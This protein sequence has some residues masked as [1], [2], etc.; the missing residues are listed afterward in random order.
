MLNLTRTS[1]AMAIAPVSGLHA[2]T[3][4]NAGTVRSPPNQQPPAIMSP[5]DAASGQSRGIAA[6]HGQ[7]P[8]KILNLDAEI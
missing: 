8:P 5:R 4:A 2:A 7:Q 1:P 3:P 6:P